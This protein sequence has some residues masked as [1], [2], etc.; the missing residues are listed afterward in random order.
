MIVVSQLFAYFSKGEDQLGKFSQTFNNQIV[1]QPEIN[2]NVET[3]EKSA[4]VES[5]DQ[6]IINEAYKRAW[7][8]LNRSMTEQK[9]IALADHFSDSLRQEILKQINQSEYRVEQVDLSHNIQ[10]HL[11]SYDKQLVA[12]KDL[13]VPCLLYTSPSPRDATLSR[14]PSSA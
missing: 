6:D 8:F 12:F 14:M 3:N 10:L 11:L 9:D 2:W 5:Q 7:Y 13:Y 4:L 1:H